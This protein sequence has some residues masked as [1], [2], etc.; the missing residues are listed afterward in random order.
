MVNATL[1]AIIAGLVIVMA[2]AVFFFVPNTINYAPVDKESINFEIC[3]PYCGGT[4]SADE[5]VLS[6]IF[7]DE[8]SIIPT[9]V[10]LSETDQN[11]FEQFLDETKPLG[12]TATPTFTLE[13]SA[14]LV[15]PAGNLVSKSSFLN[16]P[17]TPASL[18]DT[19]GNVLVGSAQIAFF[20]KTTENVEINADGTAEFWLDDKLIATK[21]VFF[22]SD[23]LKRTSTPMFLDDSITSGIIN[24]PPTTFTFKFTDESFEDLSTHTYRVILKDFSVE[25]ISQDS[26]KKYNWSGENLAYQLVMNAD[27]SQITITD[28]SGQSVSVF[29]DDNKMI[30]CDVITH[31]LDYNEDGSV[32]KHQTTN[33]PPVINVIRKDDNKLIATIDIMKTQS[34]SNIVYNVDERDGVVTCAIFPELQRSTDYIFRMEG[35]DYE[36]TTPRIQQNILLSCSPLSTQKYLTNNQNLAS[37]YVGDKCESTFAKSW[38]FIYNTQTNQKLKINSIRLKVCGQDTSTLAT[39]LAGDSRHSYYVSSQSPTFTAP[40]VTVFNG[41]TEIGKAGGKSYCTYLDN[42]P[43]DKTLTFQVSANSNTGGTSNLINGVYTSDPQGTVPAQSF[44][45]QTPPQNTFI[46]Y[47][48]YISANHNGWGNVNP[49]ELYDKGWTVKGNSNFG[50]GQ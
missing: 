1:T 23:G 16:I 24:K 41:S 44:S 26:R 22:K 29:K 14:S 5:V 30:V 45:V 3:P 25:T 50:Y 19:Q 37:V 46:E 27:K 47:Y 20:G 21:K 2:G 12:Q 10:V 38:D 42:L 34:T 40:E 7:G 32:K 18:T 13:T 4:V 15:D 17:L 33:K 35:K 36:Y 39:R 49:N 28:Q 8:L 48:L 6:E 9:D 31:V 11:A 43:H